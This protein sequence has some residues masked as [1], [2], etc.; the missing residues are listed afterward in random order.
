MESNTCVLLVY[1]RYKI[2]V[3]KQLLLYRRES[4]LAIS[5]SLVTKI[6]SRFYWRTAIKE[7]KRN[8]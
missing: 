4:N 6:M 3:C 5:S 7:K 8:F 2:F 1:R